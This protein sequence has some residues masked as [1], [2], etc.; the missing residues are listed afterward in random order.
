METFSLK[1]CPAFC[2]KC[3][4][5]LVLTLK[6]LSSIVYHQHEQDR[7][8]YLYKCT[9]VCEVAVNKVFKWGHDEI[10]CTHDGAEE[11]KS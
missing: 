3:G 4:G 8:T 6:A 5:K 11:I 7:K 9:Y 2:R 10:Q 1:N